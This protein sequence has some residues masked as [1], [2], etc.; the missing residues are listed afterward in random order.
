MTVSIAERVDDDANDEVV[1]KDEGQKEGD[2][3][4][5][6]AFERYHSMEIDQ[7]RAKAG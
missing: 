4:Q 6:G 5:D 2:V 1:D 3:L 7:D